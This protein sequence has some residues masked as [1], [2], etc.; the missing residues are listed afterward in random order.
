MTQRSPRFRRRLALSLA[1]LGLFVVGVASA[2]GREVT[3][4]GGAAIR[5]V[6]SGAAVDDAPAGPLEGFLHLLSDPNIA[7]LLFVIGGLGL[8]IELVHPNLLTGFVGALCLILAF[9]GFGSLPLNLGGLLLVGLG[10]LLFVLETQIVSHGLLTLAGIVAFALGA[11]ALY[12]A[13][14]DPAQPA[15]QVAAPVIAVTTISAAL[16]MSLIGI[17]AVRTRRMKASAGTVGVPIPPGSEGVVQA[18]L[19][20]LGTVYL[21]DEP[22]SGRTADGTVLARDTP[23]RLLGFEGLVAIVEP[24]HPPDAGPAR[25][26]PTGRA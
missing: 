10:L 23:V 12:T 22:W 24:I 20:P 21:A 11:S 16:L 9:V 25:P 4:A 18:P 26:D 15:V 13:P 14:G 6:Q 2:A 8:I 7:F 19:D 3:G 5:L 1:L 17:A